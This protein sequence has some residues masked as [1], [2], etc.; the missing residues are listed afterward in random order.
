MGLRFL[1]PLWLLLLPLCLGAVWLIYAKTRGRGLKARVSVWLRSL[2]VCILC[3]ALAGLSVTGRDSGNAV[4][5]L[6]DL[7]ESAAKSRTAMEA[8][9]SEAL[10]AMPEGMQGGVIAFGEDAMVE[11]SLSENASFSSS[12]TSVN[13]Q[14]TDLAEAL[15]LAMALIPEDVAGQIAVISDG[16]VGE[17]DAQALIERGIPV[18]VYTIENET[19]TDAQVSSVDI[20]ST[21]REGQAFTVTVMLYAQMDTRGTLVLYAGNEPVAT[22][23]VSLRKGE[24]RYS[25]EIVA[26]S[27]GVMT[28]TA[29][30]IAEGDTISA[31]N[32]LSAYMVVQGAPSVLLVEGINGEGREMQKM[33]TAAGMAVTL[34]LPA[35]MPNTA[36]TLRQ[37][38]SIVLVNVDADSFTGAQY[39]ALDGAVRQM[40]RGLVVL[41]GDQSYALGNYRGSRLEELLP[42]TID[43]EN[44]LDMPSVALVLVIDKSGSM[45]SGMF[46]TS[47]LE[48]AKEAAMRSVE[49]L[50][51]KD[52]VGVI[53]F[54]DAAKW[55]VNLQYVE[56]VAAIQNAIGT[57]RAGGGTAF[58]TPLANA[59]LAL[60]NCEATIKHVIF[61]TDGEPGDSGYQGIV[62]Q[63]AQA[64]ITMTT[65]AVGEGANA[66]LLSDLAEMGGG[67]FYAAGEFD[68]IPKI[69]T[70]ETYLISGS[71]VQNRV[72]TPIITED[73]TLTTYDGFP[74]LSGY[75]A[76]MQKGLSTVSLMSDREEPI[77]AWWRYGTGKVLA[78]TSDVKGGWTQ[79]FLSWDN[80]AEFFSGMV[81]FSLSVNE[82]EG[83][84]TMTDG[85]IRYTQPETDERSL[86][87]VAY[88]TDPDGTERE[89]F[90]SE[91]APGVYEAELD[92]TETGAYA[93]RVE[94]HDG[95][96]TARI[97]EGGSVV[98][99]SAEYDLTRGGDKE[100][101]AKLAAATGG[102]VVD[103]PTALTRVYERDLRVWTDWTKILLIAFVVLF[104][105]DVALRRLSWD[106][107]LEKHK[108]AR[109][110][111]ALEKKAKPVEKEKKPKPVVTKKEKSVDK[112]ADSAE[113]LLSAMKG[114]KKM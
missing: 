81:A 25:F 93:V 46:G 55:V 76:T 2:L 9:V 60:Q 73:S 75:L 33:L 44:K 103:T 95:T 17:I 31:N 41:G 48:L 61:L 13:R 32:S 4:W 78:W 59:Y 70:K 72:F 79:N 94:Q 83:E 110:Q 43:V 37:Y 99:Y 8:A 85:I 96:S 87:T 47:R 42:V 57:I 77:L 104:V 35:N 23:D 52:Q 29:K 100:A 80:A 54:D 111:R 18:D 22:R 30:L 113:E 27:P 114:R 15:R 5:I 56:D 88:V 107:S 34:C 84:M 65:V 98:S 28:Y 16:E 69:F 62:Q 68:N 66:T 19:A 63:M 101:L 102:S 53:A 50:T 108:A 82:Q 40:G 106:K 105:L 12:R 92:T 39:D 24:N 3:L 91:V 1:E 89:I 6:L 112:A 86:D 38:D 11:V 49:V 64:G 26:Q 14:G 7:S 109:V 97:L 20:P 45:T 67:R 90:L 10:S 58:Y 51:S 36:E 74:T 71:Y 21:V